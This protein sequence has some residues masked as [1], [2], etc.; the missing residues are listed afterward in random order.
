[1]GVGSE[2]GDEVEHEGVPR[3]GAGRARVTGGLARIRELAEI[4]CDFG[5][6][7]KKGLDDC[8]ARESLL[9]HLLLDQVF[10]PSTDFKVGG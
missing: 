7:P 10:E 3:G 8:V 1:V 4:L 9:A 2:R 6:D 5:T